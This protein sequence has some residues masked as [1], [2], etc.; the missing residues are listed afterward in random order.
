MPIPQKCS[1]HSGQSTARGIIRF[2]RA[3][4]THKIVF[5]VTSSGKTGLQ[6]EA[7]TPEAIQYLKPG[8][9]RGLGLLAA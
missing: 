4:G 9:N 7:G 5:V 1:S 2:L 8:P 3:R 6:G